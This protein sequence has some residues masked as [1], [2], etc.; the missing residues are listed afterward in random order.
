MYSGV[1][2][3]I[4][5]SLD[6][7]PGDHAV[8]NV[9]SCRCSLGKLFHKLFPPMRNAPLEVAIEPAMAVLA[10]CMPLRIKYR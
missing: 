3:R 5:I 9:K 2:W 8:I 7:A 10:A 4:Y 1:D 6:L